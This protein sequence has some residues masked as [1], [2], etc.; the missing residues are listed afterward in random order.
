MLTDQYAETVTVMG[1][2][3]T[4]AQLDIALRCATLAVCI[5]SLAVG[6]VRLVR[7]R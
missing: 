3:V 6:I 7:N 1:R 2:P 5:A 4:L